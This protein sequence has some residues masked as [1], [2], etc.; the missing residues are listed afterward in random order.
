MERLQAWAARNWLALCAIGLFVGTD[1]KLRRRDATAGTTGQLDVYILLELAIYAA[2]GGYLLVRRS[3]PPRA[4]RLPA[5]LVLTGA[6]LLTLLVS[7]SATPYKVFGA[8]RVVETA[9]LMLCALIAARQATRDDLHRMAHAFLVLV[10]VS[11]GY[12]VLVPSDPL[13]NLQAG[14]FTWLALHPGRAGAFCGVAAAIAF[15]Y[16]VQPGPRPGP[17]WHRGLY[18]AFLLVAAGAVY[19]THARAAV[20]GTVAALVT[21][22][23]SVLPGAGRRVEL[24]LG[25][26][27]GGSLAGLLA[28][29]PIT[30]YLARGENPEELSTLNA[31]TGLWQA[32]LDAVAHRPVY[33]YGVGASQG[34]FLDTV[35]LGGGHNMVINVVVDLGL[36]GLLVW[37]LLVG[38]TVLRVAALPRAG[39]PALQVDRA[40]LVGVLT[41]VL[42]DG[43]F[44][45]GPGGVANVS[46]TWF[47][48]VVGWLCCL[49]RLVQEERV[50]A[51]VRV[52]P[53]AALSGR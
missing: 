2:V 53:D 14:R 7:L 10:A 19:E 34:I 37:V 43:I 21:V 41:Y 33:G 48:L 9:I 35:G 39:L 45:A 8:A 38:T 30:A 17:R 29:D 12:G 27:A 5:P 16:L 36:F 15:V 49:V 51:R 44:G 47:F 31:R 32:A 3:S 46:A 22:A 24:V 18:L 11:V 28:L 23:W 13:S 52:A 1:Y 20:A 42:V 4:V 25:L 50:A 26:A 6:Y 40:V